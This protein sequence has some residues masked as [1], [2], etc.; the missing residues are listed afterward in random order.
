MK[1]IRYIST[2]VA[3]LFL[4]AAPLWSAE[5]DDVMAQLDSADPAV[6]VRA[7]RSIGASKTSAASSKLLDLMENS[8][9]TEVQASAAAALGAIGESENV[10]EALIRVAGKAESSRVRY[11]SML[12]LANLRSD[13]NAEQVDAV[14]GANTGD[15]MDALVRDLAQKLQTRFAK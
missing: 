1:Q 15:G 5:S 10:L 3:I 8:S 11:A 4:A 9:N 7:I 13:E 6:Q 12:A 2:A 14:I